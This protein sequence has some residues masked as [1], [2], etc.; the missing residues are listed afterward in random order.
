MRKILVWGAGAAIFSLLLT[1]SPALAGGKGQG[2]VQVVVPGTVQVVQPGKGPP[3]GWCQ[4]K[5]TGWQKKGA[6][7]PPGL[8]KKGKIPPGQLKKSF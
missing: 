3:P 4:G 2:Q 8:Q 1:G 6:V 7:M 5:K